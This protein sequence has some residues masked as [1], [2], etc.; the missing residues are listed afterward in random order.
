MEAFAPEENARFRKAVLQ[1]WKAMDWDDVRVF[2]AVARK[3]SLSA[4][5]EALQ[6][7]A[8][9]V[10]RRIEALE[11]DLATSLFHRSPTGYTPTDAGTAA[12]ARAE[13]AETALGALTLELAGR[14][15]KPFGTVRAAMPENFAVGLVA[16]EL[17]D[18][19][20]RYPGVLLELATGVTAVNLSR[21]DAD[22]ALRLVRPTSGELVFRKAG[23][24]AWELYAA[25]S[26]LRARPAEERAIVWDDA[27][28]DL[29]PA[30][31]VASHLPDV[32]PVIK[33]T[34]LQTHLAACK[35]GIGVALLPCFLAD[36]EEELV[37]L[38]PR[39]ERLVQEIWVVVHAEL[40]A[41]ARVRAVS[42]FLADVVQR[43]REQLL[44]LESA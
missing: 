41:T 34:S 7:S 19:H 42:E 11:R 12:L 16:P 29:E 38:E 6:M 5:G 14:D 2:L 26:Y 10:S 13:A 44:G 20:A 18:F 22:L 30:R 32:T 3:G 1:L 9:T 4:A 43:R 39:A 27:L 28:S 17:P 21:R 31:W 40:A 36:R 23:D 24:M 15:T 8:S 33:A 25:R 35:A 37:R